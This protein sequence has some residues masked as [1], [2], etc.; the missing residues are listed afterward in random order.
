M[1]N[2]TRRD[3]IQFTSISPCKTH[4]DS[5]TLFGLHFLVGV[6]TIISHEG[7][8]DSNPSAIYLFLLEPG[9]SC[10]MS[11]S[12]VQEMSV[13]IILKYAQAILMGRNLRGRQQACIATK[14]WLLPPL[15]TMPPSLMII[16]IRW[17]LL[18][19]CGWPTL[20]LINPLASAS[21]WLSLQMCATMLGFHFR[22]QLAGLKACVNV[23][24]S[25]FKLIDVSS[26]SSHIFLSTKF[27]PIIHT[28]ISLMCFES[29]P[30]CQPVCKCMQY[31]H[32]PKRKSVPSCGF[33][34]EMGV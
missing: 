18:D 10:Q 4:N 23:S 16:F 7:W 11:V 13:L 24:G 29:L 8:R 19:S 31:G 25:G 12:Q 3:C 22:L 14:T 6:W 20:Y 21:W 28:V 17:V 30:S 15:M 27:S 33:C 2:L 32:K 5:L 26:S 9:K 34:S 1:V